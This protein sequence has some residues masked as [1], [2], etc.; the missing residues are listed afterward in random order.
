MPPPVPRVTFQG[1]ITD[2]YTKTQALISVFVFRA[3]PREEMAGDFTV[4]FL[5]GWQSLAL[6]PQCHAE[7]CLGTGA[8]SGLRPILL[9]HWCCRAEQMVQRTSI[10]LPVIG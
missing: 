3:A 8:H 1:N 2:F 6:F 4:I 9:P 10:N 5:G 7:L